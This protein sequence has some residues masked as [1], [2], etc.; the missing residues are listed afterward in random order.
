MSAEVAGAYRP[1]ESYPPGTKMDIDGATVTF[2]TPDGEIVD[3]AEAI[4]RGWLAPYTLVR[5]HNALVAIIAELTRDEVV[6]DDGRCVF[7]VAPTAA[8]I[9]THTEG[10]PWMAGRAVVEG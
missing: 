3:A 6:D 4:E 10:C 1:T 8:G 7:C 5:T 9:V 2:T